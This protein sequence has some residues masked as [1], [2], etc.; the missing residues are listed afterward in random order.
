MAASMMLSVLIEHLA[1]EPSALHGNGGSGATKKM[2]TILLHL[3]TAGSPMFIAFR[4]LK[5]MNVD[6]FLQVP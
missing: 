3:D 4:R 5:L 2:D 6:S 1:Q